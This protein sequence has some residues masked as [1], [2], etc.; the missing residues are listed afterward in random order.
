MKEELEGEQDGRDVL[1]NQILKTFGKALKSPDAGVQATAATALAKLMLAQLLTDAD[2]LRQLVVL[3]FDSDTADNHTLRQGLSYF[4]PVYCHVL[5]AN[6]RRMVGVACA[7]VSK[8]A[9]MEEEEDEEAEAEGTA[10]TQVKLA[11]V[12]GM[13]VEWTDP[14]QA[15]PSSASSAAPAQT[16]FYLAESILERLVTSQLAREE[17]KVLLSML[18]KLHLG[19]AAAADGSGV[20][21]ELVKSVLELLAEAQE[22]KVAVDAS[23]RNV[24]AK[25]QTA[26]LRLVREVAEAERGGDETVLQVEDERVVESTEVAVDDTEMDVEEEVTRLGAELRDTTIGAPDAEGT[27]VGTDSR[28]GCISRFVT[29]STHSVCAYRPISSILEVFRQSSR[30]TPAL[31]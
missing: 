9:A 21:G 8:V 6:A 20:D 5:P 10:T 24:L 7:V 15:V 19:A 25:L 30:Q 13:L 2:L 31:H 11:S 4:L 1:Q 17:R 18:G 3:F 22:A 14:R 23:G 28:G 27:R 26:M 16:H 29:A 12:G